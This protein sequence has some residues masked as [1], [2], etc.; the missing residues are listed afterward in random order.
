MQKEER[1]YAWH[2]A[3]RLDMSQHQNVGHIMNNTRFEFAAANIIS[4]ATMTADDNDLEIKVIGL[5]AGKLMR[6]TAPLKYLSHKEIR[7][8]RL[9]RIEG[10]RSHHPL[11][12][13]FV[14][15]PAA[16]SALALGGGQPPATPGHNFRVDLRQPCDV[17]KRAGRPQ[18]QAQRAAK[19][20]VPTADVLGG[21][22]GSAP[23]PLP[24]AQFTGRLCGTG[25]APP[26]AGSAG[27]PPR[28][29]PSA[30]ASPPA[31]QADAPAANCV[32]EDSTNDSGQQPENVEQERQQQSNGMP[33]PMP[34]PATIE[35]IGTQRVGVIG[36]GDEILQDGE[37]A[38]P[39][40]AP[41]ER[42]IT[43]RLSQEAC[44]PA[45]R[46]QVGPAGGP[47]PWP[48]PP[49]PAP[50]AAHDSAAGG[51][52][53][54]QG[55][56]AGG[57]LPGQGGPAG[58]HLLSSTS[59]AAGGQTGQGGSRCSAAGAS[60]LPA[61]LMQQP[62]P[63]WQQQFPVM[64]QF[65]FM[66]Q[67]A[68]QNVCCGQA[69]N[70]AQN[71]N[72][73]GS[74]FPGTWP[75]T[76][77]HVWQDFATTPLPHGN[78]P[79]PWFPMGSPLAYPPFS[80][81]ATQNACDFSGCHPRP[82]VEPTKRNL[83]TKQMLQDAERLQAQIAELQASHTETSKERDNLLR[84]N[85]GLKLKFS[86]QTQQVKD[87]TTNARESQKKARSE[88]ARAA[89]A[90]AKLNVA[91]KE[92]DAMRKKT[93][94][95]L[96][97]RDKR[98]SVSAD[99][100]RRPVH[101]V[102]TASRAGGG[103]RMALEEV[104]TTTKG[105]FTTRTMGGLQYRRAE[106]VFAMQS[107]VDEGIG[108]RSTRNK[109]EE[110]NMYRRASADGATVE[111]VLAPRPGCTIRRMLHHG[112][113]VQAFAR[114][115]HSTMARVVR[116]CF[117]YLLYREARERLCRANTVVLIT[118]GKSFGGRHALGVL[119][120]MY[121]M[122]PG[123]R[124]DPFG[125]GP[126]TRSVLP[127]PLQLQMVCNKMAQDMYDRHGNRWA[128]Q[129]P[130]HVIRALR[131][132][133][134]EEVAK[135]YG[136]LLC[137]TT[138]AAGDNRGLGQT[139][140]TM[141]NMS[142][143]NSLLEALMISGL[144][145]SEADEDLRRRGLLDILI[146]F[147]HG[148]DAQLHLLTTRLFALRKA[149]RALLELRC[150]AR[151]IK[152][153]NAAVGADAVG[154]SLPC[155]ESGS[156]KTGSLL[157]GLI[158]TAKQAVAAAEE[159]L[160]AYAAVAAAELAASQPALAGSPALLPPLAPKEPEPI[161]LQLNGPLMQVP[162]TVRRIFHQYEEKHVRPLLAR[163]TLLRW[164]MRRWLW[165]S[166]LEIRARLT[167]EIEVLEILTEIEFLKLEVVIDVLEIEIETLKSKGRVLPGSLKDLGQSL[168]KL[169]K[170]MRDLRAR[171]VNSRI[172]TFRIQRLAAWAQNL[173]DEKKK[174]ATKN[175]TNKRGA[176]AHTAK[177]LKL[178]RRCS[179]AKR[180]K[181]GEHCP[182]FDLLC[183]DVWR[184]IFK[185]VDVRIRILL[186]AA[187]KVSMPESPSR[188]LPLAEQKV[189]INTG[190]IHYHGHAQQCQNHA[191]N[192]ILDPCIRFLDHEALTRIIQAA[193]CLKNIFNEDEL[194][195]AIDHLFSN[196]PSC[197]EI[198]KH[199]DFFI[200][201]REG[202]ASQA[203]AGRGMSLEEVKRQIGYT[204]ERGA[205]KT[206]TCA[207]VRWSTT[208]KAADWQATWRIAYAFGLLR[209]GG[210]A[211]EE[212]TEVDAAVSLFSYDGFLSDKFAD[213]MLER[214]V[215]ETFELLTGSRTLLQL[216][217]LQFL[218][219]FLFKPLMLVMGDNLECGDL[220]VGMGSIP[221][222]MLRVLLRVLFVGG[223]WSRKLAHGHR[224]NGAEYTLSKWSIRFLN[225]LCGDRVRRMLGDGWDDSMHAS[226]LEGMV[227]APSEL[228]AAFRMLALKKDTLMPQE[229]ELVFKKSHPDLFGDPNKDSSYCLRMTQMQF[230]AQQVI[231]DTAE[232]L[233]YCV[234]QN[235]QGVRAFIAGM[236]Q[237]R[238]TFGSVSCKPD[239][240][241]LVHSA[242]NYAHEMALADAAITLKLGDEMMHEAKTAIEA[243]ARKRPEVR[244]KDPLVFWP[245]YVADAFGVEGKKDTQ[246]FL[247]ISDEQRQ[248]GEWGDHYNHLNS[249]KCVDS[250]GL[251][252]QRSESRQGPSSKGIPS[253]ARSL[254]LSA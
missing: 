39:D 76:P 12:K 202:I 52:R 64:Q 173:A 102:Q 204:E 68:I 237:T 175:V 187:A 145:W 114:P 196:E 203:A 252:S 239:G 110:A 85:N 62:F 40:G 50:P 48:A 56:P 18:R 7:D 154:A 4:Y 188:F 99:G 33:A 34:A 130:F 191:A 222:R 176:K 107:D 120:C 74:Q 151:K 235:L 104:T 243:L 105:S 194:M 142:G 54:G 129:T 155:S 144:D 167:I 170:I 228:I 245:A 46:W 137:S 195:A 118:D 31:G 236:M 143:K 226:I 83:R 37:Q 119:L 108:S 159:K 66:H 72:C 111:V 135:K 244:G 219:R 171:K 109:R 182:A 88:A 117:R 146:V 248:N 225:P 253:T 156:P 77:Q 22:V 115:S 23:Q 209:I 106:C 160:A 2:F 217:L 139:K 166:H 218:H 21:T 81:S 212:Q 116:P 8:L 113:A 6:G 16:N 153:A 131:L 36:P 112:A 232:Q 69:A 38:L 206:D 73:P 20:A 163:Q 136:H 174:A 168:T 60:Q 178:Q 177:P 67:T 126:E 17:Q 75:S 132:A 80:C 147:H 215:A 211:F 78:C 121:F 150:K 233:A 241:K 15:L 181:L 58:G 180:N 29:P 141:D 249:L 172:R 201:C 183:T 138:D 86:A 122:E 24:S 95:A 13:A 10:D 47:P 100:T 9:T 65:T 84:E 165:V 169:A 238:W 190:E 179:Q 32:H 90:E 186:P 148:S 231:Q 230:L 123:D 19:Q 97:M 41:F 221:R 51:E 250:A 101:R 128:L 157:D 184:F 189:D 27:Q 205:Q 134:L 71:L 158:A 49:A 53:S 98:V 94:R 234:R 42:D 207:I 162:E 125:N 198:D 91:K 220:M 199:T 254:P 242:I 70:I 200:R 14:S 44:N 124:I 45:W 103:K 35:Q 79:T 164:W 63:I 251:E 59:P 30:P 55:G 61:A 246:R 96:Q 25:H 192:N 193:R 247:G 140:I 229:A 240:E 28:P 57:A 1:A 3:F 43:Q 11:V 208:T 26:G 223:T 161:R 197:R 185:F 93:S 87:A 133:G 216:F 127:V 227:K 152:A 224:T 89:R 210:I 82:F 214:K 92:V 149:Q 5:I 213:L